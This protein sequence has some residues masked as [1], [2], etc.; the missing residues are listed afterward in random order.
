MDKEYLIK[1]WL[2]HDLNVEE[3]E[4]F[5]K[6]KDFDALMKLSQGLGNFKA[7]NFDE[8]HQLDR[9][10]ERLKSN[11]L[12]SNWL[13]PI[14]RIAAIVVIA[15]GSFWFINKSLVTTTSTLASQKITLDLPDASEVFLNA[16]SKFTYNENKWSS[17]REVKLEG[18]AFFKVA[19]GSTFDVKTS[20]GIIRVM[21]TQFNV[22]Q[23][24]DYFEVI[25][26]EGLVGVYYSN[27]KLQKLKPGESYLVI[28]GKVISK[29]YVDTNQPFW[30][31]NESQF[32][33]MPYEHVL[34][35][36]ERQY[37]VTFDTNDINLKQLFSGNFSHDNYEIAIKAITLPLNLTYSKNNN[38]ITLKSE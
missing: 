15:V 25:C 23:R 38:T 29:A 2:D 18:E 13:K 21:G 37:D 8:K 10:T 28:D 30:L 19:K 1:K 5:K 34:A 31:L 6:L 33:S 4:A 32:E 11:K 7:P 9:I 12:K 35:E 14:L 16:G 26:Y 36:F 24:D 27:H 22:K 17:K 3:L 20:D